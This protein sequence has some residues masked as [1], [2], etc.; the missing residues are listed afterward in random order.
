MED[1]NI[2]IPLVSICMPAYNAGKYITETIRS[3]LSQTYSNWELIIVND[4]STDDT[5]LII[6]TQFNDDRIQLINI[7]NSGAATARNTAYRA[8]KGTYIKFLDSDDLIN[9]KMI[10]AQVALAK[11]EHCIIS[12]SWGR[13]YNDDLATFRLYPEDCWKTLKPVEW[14]C[15]SWKDARSMTN[16]GIF[17]IPGIIIEKAGL[18]DESLSLLD[19]MEYFT[20][21]ILA[22]DEV[23]FSDPSVLY[24]RSGNQGSLSGQINK[25]HAQSAY[26][27]V[28]TSTKYLIAVENSAITQLL[29]ANSLQQLLYSFY[30]DF[31]E[32]CRSI[33][34]DIKALGGST[35]KWRSSGRGSIIENFIG[36]RSAKKISTWLR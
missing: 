16:P 24:Y 8:S 35:A 31:P 32:L 13:F 7:N 3:V 12:A 20:K 21:T 29:S 11:N 17:L 2:T 19:D 9:P 22:A 6:E 14:I 10:E 26:H 1:N 36:W 30:P 4:G 33:E 25:T 27:S 23:I 34:K 5:R 18:W 15:S 28:L